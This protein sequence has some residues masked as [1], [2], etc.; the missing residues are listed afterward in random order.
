MSAVMPSGIVKGP[1]LSQNCS[2][3]MPPAFMA[4]HVRARVSSKRSRRCSISFGKRATRPSL[5]TAFRTSRMC[6][7]R[8]TE[9]AGLE[10]T[11]VRSRTTSSFWLRGPH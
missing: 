11:K 9:D 4:A 2:I 1:N 10:P 5:T 6:F 3:D 7:L 8:A